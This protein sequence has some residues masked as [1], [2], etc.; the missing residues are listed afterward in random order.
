MAKSKTTYD[1]LRPKL[2][3]GDIVLF[4][5]KGGI[6]AGIK[7]F[8]NSRWSHVGMVLVLPEF[9]SVML[10]ESTT[11]SKLRD[12]DTDVPRSGVQLVLLSDKLVDY[13]GD[14]AMRLLDTKD[15]APFLAPLSKLRLKLRGRPYEKDTI[16][17]INAAYDGPFG[18]NI[19]DLSS[20]FCSELVAAAYQELKLLPRTKAANEYTPADFSTENKNLALRGARLSDEIFVER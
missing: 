8:T 20:L 18:E 3:T 6:S 9:E 1:R 13:P 19:E 15:R 2:G 12:K 10:W 11:L 14:V 16:E 7:W 4:S 17:L 5:G